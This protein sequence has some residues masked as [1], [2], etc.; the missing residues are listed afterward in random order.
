LD[1]GYEASAI[2]SAHIGPVGSE[3]LGLFA[4]TVLFS[5]HV[6]SILRPGWKTFSSDAKGATV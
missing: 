4:H 1:S 2:R 6:F 3:V 5:N